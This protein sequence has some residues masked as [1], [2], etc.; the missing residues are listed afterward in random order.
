MAEKTKDRPAMVMLQWFVTEQMEE[1][2]A[3]RA[4][5]GRIRLAGNSG[6]GLLMI[7]QEMSTGRVPGMPV[8]GGSQAT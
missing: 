4:V 6:L 8:E 2:A 1:E 5:L 3:A 7:D